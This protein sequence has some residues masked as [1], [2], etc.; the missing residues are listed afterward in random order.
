M[1]ITKIEVIRQVPKETHE[2][3]VAVRKLITTIKGG[4][5]YTAVLGDVV[6]A[7]DGVTDVDDEI[8]EAGL[9]IAADGVSE[10]L[11]A[12]HELRAK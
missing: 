2:I 10:I 3:F 8:K 11:A 4:G 1:P 6:R 9:E 5:D 12:I 7:V